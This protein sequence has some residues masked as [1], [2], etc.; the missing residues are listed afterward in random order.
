MKEVFKHQSSH[1]KPPSRIKYEKENPPLS[2]RIPREYREK[3]KDYGV[4]RCGSLSKYLKRCV[5]IEETLVA[6]SIETLKRF[7]RL[8]PDAVNKLYS[9]CK[10]GQ[11]K[12]HVARSFA[13]LGFN[14]TIQ[15][16]SGMKLNVAICLAYLFLCR[17][18]GLSVEK[19]ALMI[20]DSLDKAGKRIP[21]AENELLR[22]FQKALVSQSHIKS[23]WPFMITD[24][25]AMI[26]WIL[27]HSVDLKALVPAQK[28]SNQRLAS[29][30]E[31]DLKTF[32]EELRKIAEKLRRASREARERMRYKVQ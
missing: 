26:A 22:V 5:N 30:N 20:N 11:R 7:F 8:S 15:A 2:V 16:S 13:D 27:I 24:I 21:L 9:L 17:Y 23:K 29:I 10:L 28:I 3:V 6:M 12:T 31:I 1:R 19:L 25:M 32:E 4:R 18:S 14:Y